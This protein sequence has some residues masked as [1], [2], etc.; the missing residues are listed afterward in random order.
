[1]LL[2]IIIIGVKSPVKEALLSYGLALALIIACL[3]IIYKLSKT[4]LF[5]SYFTWFFIGIIL[6]ICLLAQTS[7]ILSG[8]IQPKVATWSMIFLL[9]ATLFPIYWRSHLIAQISVIIS[10][11]AIITVFSI[12]VPMSTVEIFAEIW[13][14]FCACLICN[15]TVYTLEQLHQREYES[16]QQMQ[17][18]LYAVA[19]DLK[20]PVLGLL[21]FLENL[22]SQPQETFELP[23]SQINKMIQASD[24]QL[25]LLDSLLEVHHSE[26]SGITCHCQPTQL[27]YLVSSLIDELE[28]ILT[29]NEASITNLVPDNLPNIS[30]DSMQLRRVYENL[31]INAIKHNPPGVEIILKAKREKNMLYCSVEDNGVGIDPTR[32]KHIFSLYSGDSSQYG[33]VSRVR[34]SPGLGL[35]LYLCRQII[36][37]HQGK[38]GVD[39]LV[40]KGTTFWFTI[41]IDVK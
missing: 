39:S 7:E 25:H 37:A 35:G 23:H 38:I 4:K 26:S 29:K 16:R 34:R 19:H 9:C 13:F 20:T 15:L 8:Y 22:L 2:Y 33:S 12:D 36:T 18:F 32:H 6:L 27:N 24:R 28:P 1:M 11:L 17:L 21:M 41:P 10:Y 31:I 14:L 40:S 30:A 5:E 3:T